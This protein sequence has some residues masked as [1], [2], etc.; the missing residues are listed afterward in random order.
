MRHLPSWQLAGNELKPVAGDQ[1]G[2]ES[3][4]PGLSLSGET[5]N[6]NVP[7][8]T[9]LMIT[10]ASTVKLLPACCKWYFNQLHNIKTFCLML[11]Y[12]LFYMFVFIEKNKYRYY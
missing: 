5:V 2:R 8:H 3:F 10:H 7:S 4:T 9:S 11:H 6:S 1:S 12:I